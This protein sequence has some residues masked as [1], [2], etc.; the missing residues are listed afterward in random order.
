MTS[1]ANL[2]Y[3]RDH[4]WACFESDGTAILG[5]TDFAQESLGDV[6]FVELREVGEAVT[7]F[8][9]FGEIES[10]KA[11]SEL[12]SPVSGTVIERNDEVFTKPELVNQAPY[13]E[14]WLIK[15]KVSDTT[16]VSKLMSAGDYDTFIE[17]DFS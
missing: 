12:V 17:P 5:V 11:V 1:P 2:K 4:D 13:E 15:V 16:D 9:P 14:G 6:V 8:Q 3:I 7:Q 10:V